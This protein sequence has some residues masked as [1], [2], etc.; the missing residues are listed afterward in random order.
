MRG[1][2][3]TITMATEKDN[4]PEQ[5][6]GIGK[7]E[8]LGENELVRAQNLDPRANNNIEHGPLDAD[9]KQDVGSEITDGEAG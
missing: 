8:P 2:P 3:E 9:P 7:P 5:Q 4:T 1:L 6:A